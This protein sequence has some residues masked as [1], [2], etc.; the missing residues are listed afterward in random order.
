MTIEEKA[1]RVSDSC[2]IN[3]NQNMPKKLLA[4]IA[5]IDFRLFEPPAYIFIKKKAE[6]NC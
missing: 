5:D 2:W 3:Y 4:A 6:I 1:C